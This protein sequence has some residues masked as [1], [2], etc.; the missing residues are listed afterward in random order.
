VLNFRRQCFNWRCSHH[1]KADS[2]FE[3]F[4]PSFNKF[5]ALSQRFGNVFDISKQVKFSFLKIQLIYI[6]IKQIVFCNYLN[7]VLFMAFMY[8]NFVF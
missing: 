4:I 8:I 7:S 3:V 2:K 5:I 1:G 6:I